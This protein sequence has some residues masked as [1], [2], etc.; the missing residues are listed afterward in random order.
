MNSGAT[1]YSTD[2]IF[3]LG[4]V[5]IQSVKY[6]PGGNPGYRDYWNF[7]RFHDGDDGYQSLWD[8]FK[9]FGIDHWQPWRQFPV[10]NFCRKGQIQRELLLVF[11]SAFLCRYW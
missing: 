7:I 6:W 3:A 11:V 8:E 5:K 10:G 4:G 1:A 9:S 2:I